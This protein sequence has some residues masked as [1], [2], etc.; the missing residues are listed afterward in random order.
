MTLLEQ[1]HATEPLAK[2]AILRRLRFKAGYAHTVFG[3]GLQGKAKAATYERERAILWAE[4]AP[5]IEAH[6]LLIRR[7]LQGER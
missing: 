1:I 5:S 6:Q 7:Y 4:T 3:A 2:Q